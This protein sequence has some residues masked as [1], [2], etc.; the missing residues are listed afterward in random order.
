MGHP[1]S[2][3]YS[4]LTFDHPK[5]IEA[6]SGVRIVKVAAGLYASAFVDDKGDTWVCSTGCRLPTKVS[7]L[8]G[9][10]VRAIHGGLNDCVAV[11]GLAH[12]TI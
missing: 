12:Y 3:L 5:K 10:T 8:Q 6:L 7:Q 9:K 4:P 1:E 11:T 2:W